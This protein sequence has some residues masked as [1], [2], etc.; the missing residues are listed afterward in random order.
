MYYTLVIKDKTKSEVMEVC[1]LAI[2]YEQVKNEVHCLH[3]VKSTAVEDA[4]AFG[5][6]HPG[7]EMEIWK[8]KNVDKGTYSLIDWDK[9]VSWH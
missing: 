5:A 1:T 8:M 9:K 2:Q 7:T 3:S 4:H 6:A